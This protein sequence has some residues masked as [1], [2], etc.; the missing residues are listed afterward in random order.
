MPR[1]LKNI[2][3][4]KKGQTLIEL[5][6]IFPLMLLLVYGVI[7]I[8]SVIST[9]LTLTHTSREGAN[10]VSRGETPDLALDAVIAS[11][12][13]TIR[14][15]NLGQWR[16]IYTEIKQTPGIPCPP[17]QPCAYEIASQP[18][19]R[20][21]Y[22]QSSQIGQ[23]IGDPVTPQDLPGIESVQ[24]GQIFDVIEVFYDYG[25]NVMTF[26]GNNINKSFYDRTIFTRVSG[27]T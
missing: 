4:S 19:V 20:G 2:C 12:S 11:A 26:I 9:Y 15:N 8:G 6:L 25:P 22:G 27:T 5:T 3:G 14:N 10:L 13:P 23:N 21:N 24:A 16:I 7:E 17:P 18:I 1:S